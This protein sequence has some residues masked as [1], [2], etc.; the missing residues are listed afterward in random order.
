MRTLIFALFCWSSQAVAADRVSLQGG[1]AEQL[2]AIE[3]VD[4]ALAEQI[5]SLRVKRGE[6]HNVESLRV[7]PGITD[8]SLD[9]LRRGTSVELG[10]PIAP[11]KTFDTVDAVM[12]EFASEPT[13]QQ[14]QAWA[15][16]YAKT[17]PVMVDRWLR[18][19][20]S[21]AALPE[22]TVEYQ[23]KDG[24]DQGFS[25]VAAEGGAL[26]LP[27]EEPFPLLDDAGVDQDATYKVRA[28]WELDK[29]VMSSE[30]IRVLSEA[31]DVAKLR[32]NVLSEVTEL[33]F[34]RRKQQV[35]ALL[36]PSK[37]LAGQVKVHLRLMELTAQLDAYTGGT[38]SQSIN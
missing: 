38:F 29:L 28:K 34:D 13:I 25:Y 7:L 37:D 3:G 22:V 26:T 15:S 32:D 8:A 5:V 16:D 33:Y 35:D 20:R 30:R 10:V 27:S 23:L 17:N 24:W 1:T 36:S 12:Q 4:H 9:A 19:S 21:F 2:E 14:V 31:Q 18:A 6:L 11:T